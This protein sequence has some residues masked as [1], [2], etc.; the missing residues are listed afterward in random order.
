MCVPSEAIHSPA[1]GFTGVQVAIMH[2]KG[3]RYA[4]KGSEEEDCG[5]ANKDV[6]NSSFQKICSANVL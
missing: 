3:H 5:Q 2:Q 6:N 4:N 1:N